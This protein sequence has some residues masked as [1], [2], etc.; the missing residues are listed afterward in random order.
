MWIKI[1]CAE[2]N[3]V[4]TGLVAVLLSQPSQH[5]RSNFVFRLGKLQ[6]KIGAFIY[7]FERMY[8]V[9]FIHD[10]KLNAKIL[11]KEKVLPYSFGQQNDIY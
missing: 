1:V 10:S 3:I 11:H 4:N 8:H 9:Y 5:L 7:S 2:K 6:I